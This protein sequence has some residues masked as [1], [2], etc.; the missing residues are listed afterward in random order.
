MSATPLPV[1]EGCSDV[2]YGFVREPGEKYAGFA[3]PITREMG[4]ATAVQQRE[5]IRQ[6]RLGIET[7]MGRTRRFFRR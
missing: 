3:W 7:Q 2:L 6:L 1:Y 4:P 5:A